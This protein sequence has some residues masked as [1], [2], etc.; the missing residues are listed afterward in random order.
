MGKTLKYGDFS[1][2]SEN[3]YTG[4]AGKQN[5]KGYARGGKAKKGGDEI[6]FLERANAPRDV[7]RHE[8][9]EREGDAEPR[10]MIIREVSLLKKVGAPAKMIRAEREEAGCAAGGPVKGK[11]Q[12]KV[13]L[14]MSEFKKGALHSGKDGNVVKNPKQALAIAMSESRKMGHGGSAAE[15]MAADKKLID[16]EIK[17]HADKPASQAHNGLKRGGKAVPS[18]SKLPKFGKIIPR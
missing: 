4:S 5:V 1:F 14:V 17:K 11:A 12:K 16:Q 8:M 10:G 3:G 2:G 13:G 9:A 6:A 7:L 15:D 18:Y